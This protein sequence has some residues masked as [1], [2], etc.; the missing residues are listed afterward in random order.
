MPVTLMQYYHE[1]IKNL[2]YSSWKDF[3][4]TAPKKEV[5]TIKKLL[6]KE[7]NKK[8]RNKEKVAQWRAKQKEKKT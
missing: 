8:V 2:G 6:K 7:F 5:D 3:L 1:Q 4:E